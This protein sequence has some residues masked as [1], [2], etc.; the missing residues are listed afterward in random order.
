[1]KCDYCEFTVTDCS[2]DALPCMLF[3]LL[4]K[5]GVEVNEKKDDTEWWQHRKTSKGGR[6]G[7]H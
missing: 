3:H 1:M 7:S 4:L 5:H 6:Y 2:K